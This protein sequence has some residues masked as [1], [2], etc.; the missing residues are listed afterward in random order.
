VAAK[1]PLWLQ[2]VLRLER[3]IGAPIE[4]AV[5]TD[6]YFELLAQAN[7]ARTRATKLTEAWTKE[8]LHLLNLPAGSDVRRLQA[9]LSRVERSLAKLS[10]EVRDARTN[11]GAE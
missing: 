6:A 11:D 3:A 2:L 9:Q 7:R 1:Q 5:R 8:W 10:K 4:S